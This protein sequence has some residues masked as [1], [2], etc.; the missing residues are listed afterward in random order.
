MTPKSSEPPEKI[1]ST[2]PIEM[3]VLGGEAIV[4]L[5][6]ARRDGVVVGPAAEGHEF[7]AAAQNV[8][9]AVHST[10]INKKLA[11]AEDSVVVGRASGV[12][13]LLAAAR[14]IRRGAASARR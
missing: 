14:D 13:Q 7:L 1:V 2:P 5:R 8:R 11:A 4:I 6:T 3:I 12:H 10:R 9:R